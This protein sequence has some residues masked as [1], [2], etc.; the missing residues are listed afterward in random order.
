MSKEIKINREQFD[1]A[2]KTLTTSI[3][4]LDANFTQGIEGDSQLDVVD[5]LNKIKED[6]DKAL[7]QFEFVFLKNI[8][9]TRQSVESIQEADRQSASQI[10][11][12]G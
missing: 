11:L 9:S 6:Y 2:I 10:R 5:A 3:K 4:Q 8:Y 12:M 7:S 1:Q